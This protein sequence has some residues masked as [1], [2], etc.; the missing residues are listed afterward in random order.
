M[1]NWIFLEIFFEE[2]QITGMLYER[3]FFLIIINE[4]I[5]FDGMIIKLPE[6]FPL[7]LASW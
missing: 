3:N 2:I 7:H 1:G 5:S 4:S 6:I